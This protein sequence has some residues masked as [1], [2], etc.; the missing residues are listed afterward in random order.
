MSQKVIKEKNWVNFYVQL[1]VVV[2]RLVLTS[3]SDDQ[4]SMTPK[5]STV[6]IN[7]FSK[8]IKAVHAQSDP[9]YEIKDDKIQIDG[10]ADEEETKVMP[11]L[12]TEDVYSTALPLWSIDGNFIK[13]EEVTEE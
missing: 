11:K 10:A 4:V 3:A 12:S 2:I 1:I 5:G 13:N 9:K 6:I 7:H 8:V